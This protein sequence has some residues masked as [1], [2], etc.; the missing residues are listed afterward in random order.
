[1]PWLHR[2]CKEWFLLPRLMLQRE[3]RLLQG[4]A[5]Q[6]G[7][8]FLAL[9]A[10]RILLTTAVLVRPAGL[11]IINQPEISRPLRVRPIILSLFTGSCTSAAFFALQS[12]S[13]VVLGLGLV[14]TSR[15][16]RTSSRSNNWRVLSI[17]SN[18]SSM[19]NLK[20]GAYLSPALRP[21]MLRI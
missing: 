15:S 8:L 6:H 21:I 2:L 1:M 14:V 4:Q 5:Y 19:R 20:S 3:V 12:M 18:V 10:H 16:R 11:S 9:K 17:R 7:R 13:E